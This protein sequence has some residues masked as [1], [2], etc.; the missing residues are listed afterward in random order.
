VQPHEVPI[1][2]SGQDVGEVTK[3]AMDRIRF[4]SSDD[5]S[6]ARQ[7]KEER[8][9]QTT[10]SMPIELTEIECALAHDRV[11]QQSGDDISA[12]N[13]EEIYSE[14]SARDPVNS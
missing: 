9:S 11:E 3:K 12:N 5:K 7:G 4:P 6:C 13:E 14:K 2:G 8:G 1:F 10:D